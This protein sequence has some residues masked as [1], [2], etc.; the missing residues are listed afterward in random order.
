[1]YE[2][3]MRQIIEYAI[4][5]GIL[6]ILPQ[7]QTMWKATIASTWPPPAWRMNMTCPSGTGE[8][9]TGA[10]QSRAGSK[11]SGWF[12]YQPGI[13]LAERSFTALQALDAVWRGVRAESPA[14]GFRLR[15]LP[16]PPQEHL[17]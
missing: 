13:C 17:T 4:G 2:K 10:P 12:S 3:N 5:K 9:G 15:Q 6:P 1:V 14:A 16:H 8:S 7:R 11:P